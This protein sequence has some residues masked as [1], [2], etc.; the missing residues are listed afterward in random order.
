VAEEDIMVWDL[1]STA[2]RSDWRHPAASAPRSRGETILVVED[3]PA[4]GELVRIMLESAGYRVLCEACTAAA[5]A[6]A[7]SYDGRIDLVLSDMML[8]GWSGREVGRALAS[9]RPQAAVLFMSGTAAEL[10]EGRRP[11]PA[12]F[13]EKPFTQAVLLDKVRELL[14][15][16]TA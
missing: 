9:L 4:L 6:L 11:A 15:S 12:H 14:D 8:P 7:G 1:S 3:D 13:L 5:L 2:D 10:I 16:M